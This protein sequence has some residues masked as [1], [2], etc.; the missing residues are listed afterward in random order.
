[1]HWHL[2]HVQCKYGTPQAGKYPDGANELKETVPVPNRITDGFTP[3]HVAFWD[4]ELGGMTCYVACADAQYLLDAG[5]APQG[6]QLPKVQQGWQLL[7]G[8]PTY[9]KSMFCT[10]DQETLKRNAYY[11]FHCHIL[12]HE[13]WDMMAKLRILPKGGCPA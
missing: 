13:E 4:R 11:V 2:L 9:L 12:E 3:N 1:M 10:K 5:A 6:Q 8:P 7:T